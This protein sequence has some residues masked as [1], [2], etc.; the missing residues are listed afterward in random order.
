MGLTKSPAVSKKINVDLRSEGNVVEV[1]PFI[2]SYVRVLFYLK[3]KPC[4]FSKSW[5]QCWY[6]TIMYNF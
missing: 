5:Y 6:Y 4:I 3:N 2:L 1:G